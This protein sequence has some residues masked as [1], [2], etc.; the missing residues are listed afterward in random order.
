M[1]KKKKTTKK[2]KPARTKAAK[3]SAARRSARKPARAS[4][5]ASGVQLTSLAPSLTVNDLAQTMAW[6]CDIL[7]FTVTQRWE[8]DGEFVGAELQSG[9]AAIYVGRDDWQMGRDRVK[10]LGFRIYW[11]TDQNIDQLA[12]RIKAKGGTLASEPK[13]EWGMRSFNLEDPTGYKI[14][15]GSN[16]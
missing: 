10:G 2:A 1:A 6:Y 8:R 4:K 14:T 7:G 15:V 11:Y 13:D 9:K 12:A 3:K 16:R 5:A